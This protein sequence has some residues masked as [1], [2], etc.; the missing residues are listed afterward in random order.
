MNGELTQKQ[1]NF[2][3][4]L[5]KGMSQRDAYIQAGYSSNYAPAIIDTN[6]C[7]LAGSNKVRIRLEELNQAV[8]V[9]TVADVQE[10]KEVLTEVIRGRLGH[11]IDAS[12]HVVD[13][14]N[15]KLL[16]AALQEVKTTEYGAE[17]PVKTTTIKLHNPITAIAELNKMGGD[18]APEK[19][20]ILGAIHVEVTYV[21]RDRN[22]TDDKDKPTNS[23]LPP[24]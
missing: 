8:E 3:L 9:D 22:Q 11:Y 18:Y 19:H 21:N 2:T 14:D 10:R 17:F 5:F 24:G 20:A 12:G 15:K 13:A 6:A 16:S 23:S 1:E 4:N 7:M